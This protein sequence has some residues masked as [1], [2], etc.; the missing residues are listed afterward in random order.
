MSSNRKTEAET[1]LNL[2]ILGES[3]VGKSTLINSIAN[4]FTYNSFEDAKGQKPVCMIPA[5]FLMRDS[6]FNT[7]TVTIGEPVNDELTQ[8][9]RT[10]NF[11]HP[12]CQI[13]FINVSGIGDPRGIVHD[14]ENI[15]AMLDTV[16][17]F[18]EIHAICILLK[19]TDTKLTPDYRLYLDALFLHLHQ[20]A[21]PN[22]VFV[23][24][25]S[26]ATDFVPENAE[27][28]LKAYL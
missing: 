17:V 5:S 13:N 19:S 9:P 26:Q 8:S 14:R 4:Y 25:N 11:R 23:F 6:D 3:G 22:V 2:L 12:Q 18:K 10:Y 1:F 21:I 24:T 27:V 28:V 16:S 7:Y 15:K 20:N